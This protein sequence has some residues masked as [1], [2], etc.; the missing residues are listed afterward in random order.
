MTRVAVFIAGILTHDAR[1][2]LTS[3]A[4]RHTVLPRKALMSV[5]ALES[6]AAD[7]VDP[8]PLPPARVSVKIPVNLQFAGVFCAGVTRNISQDGAFIATPW[9]LP[10]GQRVTLRLAV[11]GH[12]APF[13]VE[14]EVR[15][16]R[17]DADGDSRPAG[18]GV[19]FVDPPI[20][21]SLCLAGLLQANQAR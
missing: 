13:E 7:R 12:R 18:I 6:D 20:G 9:R 5:A 1:P 11:P 10:V 14:A 17:P 3:A 8:R 21:V 16:L 19:Q 4:A 15:W 2:Q